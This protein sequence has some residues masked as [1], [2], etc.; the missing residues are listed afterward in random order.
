MRTMHKAV[1]NSIS[2]Y[3]F[4]MPSRYNCTHSGAVIVEE[5][6]NKN[7]AINMLNPKYFDKADYGNKNIIVLGGCKLPHEYMNTIREALDQLGKEVN[8]DDDESI[9]VFKGRDKSEEY[10]IINHSKSTSTSVV[11]EMSEYERARNML[12]DDWD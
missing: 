6:F 7:E 12:D 8:N 9:V 10:E 1:D 3:P 11:S 4:V 5:Y 2:N